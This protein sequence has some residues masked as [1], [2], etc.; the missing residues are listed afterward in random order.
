MPIPDSQLRACLGAMGKLIEKR[1]PPL[2]I[3]EQLDLRADINGGEAVIFVVRPSFQ[4]KT[5][6]IETPVAK[7]KWVNTRSV[8]RL[9]WM[10][11]DRKWYS[12]EPL[13]ESNDVH[14]LLE[15]VD[16]DPHCCFWG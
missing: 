3:R 1:R 11:A 13:P 10:R 9:F 12:Y 16:R 6:I 8:W 7:A 4:D 14:V 2:H 5:R 15:E